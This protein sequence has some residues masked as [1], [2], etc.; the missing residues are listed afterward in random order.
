MLSGLSATAAAQT[1][2]SGSDDPEPISVLKQ[3]RAYGGDARLE[4]LP[5]AGS[6]VMEQ[7]CAGSDTLFV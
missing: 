5:L 1:R 7:V 4:K 6:G 3:R 2:D